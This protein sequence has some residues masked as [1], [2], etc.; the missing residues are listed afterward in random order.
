MRDTLRLFLREGSSH[1]AA[2]EHFGL[3][4]N[5]VGYR[6][7]K[8][9]ERRGK[10]IADDQIEVEMAPLVCDQFHEAVL[11]EGTAS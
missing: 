1:T 3:H 6:V 9:I 7:N 10:P 11:Q 4:R 2:A 8:A 5:T